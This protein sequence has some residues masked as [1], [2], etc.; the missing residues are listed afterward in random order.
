MDSAILGLVLESS[1]LIAAERRKLSFAEA[2]V[3]IQKVIG[4]LP[5][6]LSAVGAAELGHGIEELPPPAMGQRSR[7][8]FDNLK[9]AVPIYPLTESTTEIITRTAR[10]RAVE[11]VTFRWARSAAASEARV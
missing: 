4:K 5:S 10:E 2:V 11:G 8:F 3:D 6:V 1:V 7:T 9:T